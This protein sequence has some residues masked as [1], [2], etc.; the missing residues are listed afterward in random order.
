MRIAH[1]GGVCF[2]H[3]LEDLISILQ[4][5]FNDSVN[6]FWIMDDEADNPCLAILVNKDIANVTF[7][8]FA[9]HPGLQSQGDAIS[10]EGFSVFYTNTPEEEIEVSNDLVISFEQAEQ[11]AEEFF[12]TNN[13]PAC[14]NWLDLSSQGI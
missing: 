6:E 5:R 8:P 14:I 3:T 7:F 1:F 2:C 12:L 11:A 9:G 10:E 13:K 4:V